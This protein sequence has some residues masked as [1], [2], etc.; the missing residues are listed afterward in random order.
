MQMQLYRDRG[1]NS[2][3]HVLVG[4]CEEAVTSG[5]VL[6]FHTFQAPEHAILWDAVPV[7]NVNTSY[8]RSRVRDFINS[9]TRLSYPEHYDR[10]KDG[11]TVK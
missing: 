6:S 11:E 2:K 3:H 8:G 7:A 1:L 5:S 10:W 9:R 4:L